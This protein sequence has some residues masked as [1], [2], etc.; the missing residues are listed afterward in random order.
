MKRNYRI[1]LPIALLLGL[2][3]FKSFAQNDVEKDKAILGLIGK[4]LPQAHYKPT[5]INDEFSEEVHANFIKALDPSKRFFLKEDIKLFDKYKYKIDDEINSKN[6][7][8]YNI[9][10]HKFTQRL[11]ETKEFYKKLLKEPFDYN[12]EECLNVDYDSVA[13]PKNKKARLNYW[14]KQLKFNTISR[15]YDKLEDE[16][17]KKKDSVDYVVK[18][19]E[20]LEKESREKV[21]ETMSDYYIRMNELE[22]ED[23]Y[24][25]Y[26]NTIAA[27]FDPH[28]YYFSPKMK[29]RFDINMSG[30]LEGIG[31]RLQK[32]GD[33]TKIVDVISGGPAWKAGDLEVGDL[34]LKVAQG[35]DEP[36]DIVGMR[37]DDAIKLIKGKKG[38]EVKL[39]IKKIDGSKEVISIIRDV[40]ELEETFAKTSVVEYD[41]KKYGLINL[42]GFY[43]DFN[44]RNSRNS[45][46]D[47][48]HEI[49]EL[50]KE[51]VEGLLIDLR[52]NGG[53]SLRTAIEI[54]GLFIDKGP[55]VQVKYKGEEPRID[56]DK[57]STIQWNG[58]LV[59]LVNELSASASE[60][61]AAAMQDYNRAVIIGSKQTFGKGTVQ[62][63][64]GLNRFSSFKGDLGALKMTVQKFYRINGGSTQLKGVSS[65]V[66]IPDRY[67]YMKI[68]ERDED[69]PLDWDSINPANYS[70]LNFYSN[71][72]EVVNNANERVN[73][74]PQFKL[75]NS[76]AKWLK[77]NQDDHKI[78]LNLD[79]FKKDMKQ[80]DE[81]SKKYD[82]IKDYKN[83][84]EFKSPSYELPLVKNDS[85]LAKKR[86]VWH[87]DLSKDIYVEEALHVVSSLKKQ[88]L[89]T[90]IKN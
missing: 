69:N 26:I 43:I 85:I 65:D 51:G 40:V 47:M 8:F 31:A 4:I 88:L 7:H 18:S 76:Y 62:N 63:V 1:V 78:Y 66:A 5:E 68:G 42:P 35:D 90:P 41:E 79:K 74:N 13:Y 16:K 87:K 2:F 23:W 49:E 44:K 11:N 21:T 37:L 56:K 33:Y 58:P 70:R 82:A 30:K 64:L 45:T 67:T 77:E 46:T 27:A 72:N 10:L 54:A 53:G 89:E 39:T 32:K 55:I 86:D 50:K 6:V 9:A 24:P 73:A 36:V 71:F 17:N 14:R 12:K 20:V 22:D 83:K 84:L 29:T 60:I 19:F 15:L 75:I 80:H 61:F 28:T 48:K 25:I 3:T 34:I 81:E 38:S 57:D 59:I 52:G